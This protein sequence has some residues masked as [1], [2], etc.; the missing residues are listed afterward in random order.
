M[1]QAD[2]GLLDAASASWERA[3][4]PSVVPSGPARNLARL[5]DKGGD[6]ATTRRGYSRGLAIEGS[7]AEAGA[8]LTTH[9]A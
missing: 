7:D 1:A 8:W 9:P 6:V 2:A 4:G 3:H 5:A